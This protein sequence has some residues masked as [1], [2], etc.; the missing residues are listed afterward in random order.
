MYI[1]LRRTKI[2]CNITLQDIKTQANNFTC[3]LYLCFNVSSNNEA[4]VIT[5]ERNREA[6]RNR[7]RMMIYS[8]IMFPKF[9]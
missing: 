6:E 5:R 1:E 2:T 4:F 7:K 9:D 8:I 3:I